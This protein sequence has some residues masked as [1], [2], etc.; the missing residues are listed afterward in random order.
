VNTTFNLLE[1][2]EGTK[3]DFWAQMKFKLLMSSENEVFP[4]NHSTRPSGC[5]IESVSNFMVS[6]LVETYR[7]VGDLTGFSD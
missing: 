7:V 2:L 1:G 6:A 3:K 5:D 4:D